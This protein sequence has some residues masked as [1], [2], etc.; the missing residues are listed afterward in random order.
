MNLPE[1]TVAR[2]CSF[3]IRSSLFDKI[4]WGHSDKPQSPCSGLIEEPIVGG[5]AEVASTHNVLAFVAIRMILWK[6]MVF[7]ESEPVGE[8]LRAVK[9]AIT[10]PKAVSLH[11]FKGVPS[12]G[13]VELRH[14]SFPLFH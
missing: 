13:V 7:R 8:R 2:P 4:F 11:C 6:Q 14:R 10:A 9:S 12:E 3:N 1:L 5:V